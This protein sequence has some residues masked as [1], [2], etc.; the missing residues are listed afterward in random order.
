MTRPNINRTSLQTELE[1]EQQSNAWFSPHIHVEKGTW[2]VNGGQCSGSQVGLTR[3][4]RSASFIHT[5]CPVP[6]VTRAK[7][8]VNRASH[9]FL[10][11]D[12]WFCLFALHCECYSCYPGDLKEESTHSGA[13]AE[14]LT[15]T[16]AKQKHFKSRL[17]NPSMG[18]TDNL[19]KS[20]A[21]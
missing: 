15:L 10:L 4:L 2:V 3:P 17:K 13:S 6:F 14:G 9:R 8:L 12:C 1:P 21:L 11:L 20:F 18:L 19:E 7:E 16:F 5:T